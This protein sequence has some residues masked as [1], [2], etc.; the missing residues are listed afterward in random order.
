M[1]FGNTNIG[2][3]SPEAANAWCYHQ[4]FIVA[5]EANK[6]LALRVL[7]P[8]TLS[9]YLCESS[10]EADNAWCYHQHFLL[11]WEAKNLFH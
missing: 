4:H 10:S 1:I 8:A 9:L 5:C 7:L 3:I 11:S 2:R 6:L